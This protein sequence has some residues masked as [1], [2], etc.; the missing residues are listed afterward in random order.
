MKCVRRLVNA[1]LLRT[2]R[3]SFCAQV[4]YVVTPKGVKFLRK[5]GLSTGLRAIEEIDERSWKH[6]LVVTEVRIIFERLIGCEGWICERALQ[7][8]VFA[9]QSFTKILER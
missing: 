5:N 7:C 1:G 2:V 9:E 4:L 8:V 6:D 3:P